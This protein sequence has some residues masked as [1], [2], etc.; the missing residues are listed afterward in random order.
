MCIKKS[1]KKHSENN[2]LIEKK[3]KRPSTKEMELE[4]AR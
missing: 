3:R 4:E 2:T 1:I